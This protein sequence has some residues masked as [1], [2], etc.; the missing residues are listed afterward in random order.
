MNN[1]SYSIVEVCNSDNNEIIDMDE[2]SKN[3]CNETENNMNTTNEMIALEFFYNE[4]YTVKDL[5]KVAGYYNIPTR[6]LKK[7][8]LINKIVEYEMNYE[9]NEL[10]SRRKLLQF[11]YEELK[12]DNYFSVFVS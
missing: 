9:N 2:L 5:N 4:N 1:I 6:K 3:M 12:N 7:E 10:V 8:Q 11:Y